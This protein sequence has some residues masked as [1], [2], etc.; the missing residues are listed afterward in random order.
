[1]ARSLQRV[2]RARGRRQ[3]PGRRPGGRAV[4]Q[5]RRRSRRRRRT[6][7][8]SRCCACPRPCPPGRS[9]TRRLPECGA[10]LI[11]SGG[12]AEAGGPGIGYQ[13]QLSRPPREAGSGAAGPEHLRVPGPGARAHRL[14]RPR[15]GRRPRRSGRGGRGQRR[16][17]PRAR[18]P[19]GGGGHRR[20]A[21]RRAGQRR[22]RHRGR[23]AGHLVEDEATRAV[24]LHVESV[25]DGPAL[26]RRRPRAE[27]PRARGRARRRPERRRRLRP[28]AHRGTGDLVAGHPRRAPAG[29][30]GPRGRR[31]GAGRR[32]HRAV[33]A[34]A[35]GRM[36]PRRR[37][38][39]RPGRPRPAARR[40]PARAGHRRPC[41][42][43]TGR[44][45]G[46]ARCCRR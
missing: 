4:R 38:G 33:G 18:L 21:R 46:S 5:R 1:M 35:A 39:H 43:A 13:A 19:A 36:Q 8:T 11:C 3:P 44:G 24:A 10:A 14:L 32:R 22:R 30:R 7:S 16:G 28:F 15:R 6:R 17:Q 29:R 25:A 23:R 27:R 34:A 41:A 9:P 20:L 26:A 42:S 31:A 12:Y 2:P 37:R 40:R 45:P